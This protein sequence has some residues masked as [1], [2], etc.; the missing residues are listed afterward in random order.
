MVYAIINN[1]NSK[2]NRTQYAQ[3]VF[4]MQALSKEAI[5]VRR[6][7]KRKWNKENR[8]KVKAAQVRYWEKKARE[9]RNAAAAE[10]K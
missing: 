10:E 1:R 2:T 6:A 3:E 8:D 4:K 7:Y 9:E 5:E